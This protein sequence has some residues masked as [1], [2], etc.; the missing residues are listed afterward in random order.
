MNEI[1]QLHSHYLKSFGEA[2]TAFMVLPLAMA[3]IYRKNLTK[4][5]KLV[6]LY[7]LILFF[8]NFSE[9]LFVWLV[10]T[11][12]NFILPYLKKFNI[13]DTNFIAII[14]RLIDYIFV[15]WIFS[16]AL[17]APISQWLKKVSW[18]LIPLAILVYFFVDGFRT[19]GTVNAIINRVYLVAVPALYFW[20][21]FRSVPN[22]SLWRNSFFLFGLGIFIPSLIGLMMSFIGDKLN[23]TDYVAFVKLS[24]FRNVLT[25]LAQFVFAFAFYQAKYVK[26]LLRE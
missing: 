22:L 10:N 7:L 13:S 1:E 23:Q 3:V 2:A 4:P 11:Y 12:T 18:G 26:F 25:I 14:G 9:S 8:Y 6:F 5:L 16:Y 21:L 20:H 24:I 19:Y 17:K 15:G